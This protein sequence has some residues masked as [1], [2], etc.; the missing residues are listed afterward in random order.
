MIVDVE[1][2]F[3]DG[4][5]RCPRFATDDCSSRKWSDGL[6]S[7]RALCRAAGL[8]ESVR[9]GHPCYRHAGRNV[10]LIGATREDFRLSFMSAALLSDPEHVLQRSGPNTRHPDTLRFTSAE[11][12]TALAP[13]I[14]A[15]LLEAAGHAGAGRRPV[16]DEGPIDVP[17]ELVQAMDDDP[18]L[19]EAFHLLT[20]GRQRSYVIA[21]SSAKTTAT[22]H[23]RVA[24]FRDRILMGKGAQER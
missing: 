23:A 24:K 2:Y 12:V 22:R 20:R 21:L 9:W 10:A 17:D 14:A 18:V 3:L 8:E 6:K 7:L 16:K 11:Q 4:C 19:A 1:H 13:V 5:G 15:Y